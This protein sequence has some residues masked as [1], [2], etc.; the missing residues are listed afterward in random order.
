MISSLSQ[1][2]CLINIERLIKFPQVLRNFKE[3]FCTATRI[4]TP[5]NTKTRTLSLLEQ[6]TPAAILPLS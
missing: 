2:F 1:R 5:L 3:R 4:E 6:E